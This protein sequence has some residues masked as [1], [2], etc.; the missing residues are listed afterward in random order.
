M[1]DI[2]IEFRK[3]VLFIRLEGI[4]NRDTIYKLNEDVLETIKNN[5]IKFIV[6][7]L[8]NLYYIDLNG[9]NA[10]MN[11]YYTINQYH[12]KA[13]ICG[14]NNSIVKSRINQSE[15][16]NYFN[17]TNNELSALKLMNL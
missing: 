8:E 7:N 14:I 13:L 2:N 16:L 17:E 4:L 12:G 10:I 1:L 5:G 9:I 6:F 3:G 11:H 15:M